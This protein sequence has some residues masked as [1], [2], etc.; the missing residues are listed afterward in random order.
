MSPSGSSDRGGSK[1]IIVAIIGA[2]S[3]LAAAIIGVIPNLMRSEAPAPP[4]LASHTA[5]PVSPPTLLSS[6][7]VPTP[8]TVVPS[9]AT[10]SK[11]M[12]GVWEGEWGNP[13]GYLY[14]FQMKLDAGPSNTLSGSI[15]WTLKKAPPNSEEANLIGSRATEFVEGTYHPESR[16]ARFEGQRED[17]PDDII[18]IDVYRVRLS[19][20]GNTFSGESFTGGTW[21]GKL[22]GRRVK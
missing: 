3:V 16:T 13:K 19:E 22:I 6:T 11:S 18:D 15:A 12:A 1:E 17:D 8:S 9:P 14:T 5:S 10:A 20:D 2:V 4:P 7:S 21:E